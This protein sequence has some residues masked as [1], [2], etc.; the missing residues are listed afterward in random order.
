M[1]IRTFALVYGIV[2]ALI[3]IAGFVPQLLTPH[4]MVEHEL[5]V[6]QGAG[7]LLGLFPVNLLHNLVHLAFGAWGLLVYRSRDASIAYARTIAIVYAV[8][9]IM[10]IVPGLDTVFGLVPLHGN[11]I[12]LHALLAG[13]AAYFGFV[14]H[15]ELDATGGA[16]SGPGVPS[17]RAR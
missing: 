9:A 4:D 14:R 3:G 17:S 5:A 10:G 2:F 11:D 8:L 15:G 7:N 12:W 16:G 13:G 1:N 6:D